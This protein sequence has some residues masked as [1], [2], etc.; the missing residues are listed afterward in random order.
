MK[1]PKCGQEY[2]AVP[3]RIVNRDQRLSS[4]MQI[5]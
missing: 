4:I 3:A 1:C 5:I 2:E